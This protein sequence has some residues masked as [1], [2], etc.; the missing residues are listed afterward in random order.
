MLQPML[1]YFTDKQRR[2]ISNTSAPMT[3]EFSQITRVFHYRVGE[4]RRRKS[5]NLTRPTQAIPLITVLLCICQVMTSHIDSSFKHCLP[6]RNV[7]TKVIDLNER[8]THASTN[9]V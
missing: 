6:Q 2:N 7:Y 3:T 8:T 1:F 5:D 4:S 9:P